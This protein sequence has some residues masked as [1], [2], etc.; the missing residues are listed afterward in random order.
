MVLSAGFEPA[1][2]WSEAKRSIQL[3][4]ESSH[5]ATDK[6]IA[7]TLHVTEHNAKQ[8]RRFLAHMQDDCYL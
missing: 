8:Y 7:D 5:A 2:S 1:T 6:L 3:S 4:Y